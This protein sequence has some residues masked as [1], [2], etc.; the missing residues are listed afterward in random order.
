[1]PN[2]TLLTQTEQDTVRDFMSMELHNPAQHEQSPPAAH[3]DPI[4]KHMREADSQIRQWQ[5]ERLKTPGNAFLTQVIRIL[6]QHQQEHTT[7]QHAENE[8]AA[9]QPAL[10]HG[11]PLPKR[12]EGLIKNLTTLRDELTRMQEAGTF[13]QRLAS[14]APFIRNDVLLSARDYFADHCPCPP[15]KPAFNQ[16]IRLHLLSKDDSG[17][18]PLDKEEYTQAIASLNEIRRKAAQIEKTDHANALCD[19]TTDRTPQEQYYHNQWNHLQD[20][21]REAPRLQNTVV[22][23]LG[24]YHGTACTGYAYKL[25]DHCES[26]MEL[27]KTLKKDTLYPDIVE[28]FDTMLNRS[29][30]RQN[31]PLGTML[32]MLEKK[33][34]SESPAR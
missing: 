11:L 9:A 31:H 22:M 14:M 20:I 7:R 30:S 18:I 34:A 32:D 24:E 5:A 19:L 1:M 33:R 4:L 3:K 28:R 8:N 16:Q 6:Q 29:R 26:L 17:E 12:R 13:S 21:I 2:S 25:S 23:T 15:A 27:L 10:K